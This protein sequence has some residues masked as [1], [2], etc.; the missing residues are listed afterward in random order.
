MLHTLLVDGSADVLPDIEQ[1][2]RIFVSK[3]N[4]NIRVRPRAHAPSPTHPADASLSG[5]AQ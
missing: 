2:L 1:A 5:H 4:F 3:Y